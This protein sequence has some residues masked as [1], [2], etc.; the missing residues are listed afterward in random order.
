MLCVLK[1]FASRSVLSA[2]SVALLFFELASLGT[3]L[4]ADFKRNEWSKSDAWKTFSGIMSDS[5]KPNRFKRSMCSVKVTVPWFTSLKYTVCVV[6]ICP[7]GVGVRVSKDLIG[8]CAVPISVV[9]D[10]IVR[11]II[12]LRVM[13]K[14]ISRSLQEAVRPVMYCVYVKGKLFNIRYII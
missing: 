9:E 3:S 11:V 5:L 2:L 7:S 6:V 8:M 13:L 1:C 4:S 12:D 10:R 14:E